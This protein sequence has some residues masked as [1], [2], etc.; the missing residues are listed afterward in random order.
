MDSKLQSL[1]SFLDLTL[2]HLSHSRTGNVEMFLYRKLL[3]KVDNISNKSRSY[4]T[5]TRNQQAVLLVRRHGKHFWTN[6][7]SKVY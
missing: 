3:L 1:K 4:I 7:F 6:L 2:Q 5:S